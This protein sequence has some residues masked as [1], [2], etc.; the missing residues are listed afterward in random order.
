MVKSR[1][2]WMMFL[3]GTALFAGER[4]AEKFDGYTYFSVGV[5]SLSY[6]EHDSV[7][8][9][10]SSAKASNPIYR[11]GSLMRINDSFDVS[12]DFLS[13]ILPTQA[14][15]TW[16]KNGTPFQT[17]KADMLFSSMKL[18]VQYKFTPQHRLLTGFGYSLNSYKRYDFNT[19][20]TTTVVE[21]QIASF[22]FEAGYGYESRP[23]GIEGMRVSGR[24]MG[25]VPVVQQ[26]KN[27]AFP[28][29]TFNS[30]QGYDV[31]AMLAVGYT[32][33]RGVD[34]GIYGGYNYSYRRGSQMSYQGGNLRWPENYFKSY[35]MGLQLAWHLED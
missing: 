23:V 11:S 20:T 18:L 12:L 33:Y 29:V 7:A 27:T 4:N 31:A 14:D 25:A 28:D 15:E 2:I 19:S 26:A 9:Y 16:T 30:T 34:V 1:L 24:L 32:V 6:D 10:E 21:E 22:K 35:E 3:L 8:Q 17:N 13:T 5:Q